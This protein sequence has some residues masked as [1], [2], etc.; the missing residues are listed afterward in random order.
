[1]NHHQ[2]VGVDMEKDDVINIVITLCCG[3]LFIQFV[4]LMLQIG[5]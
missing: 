3:W 4:E 5:Y 1:M 2:T